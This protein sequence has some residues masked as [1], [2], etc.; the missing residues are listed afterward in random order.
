MVPAS[1]MRSQSSHLTHPQTLWRPAGTCRGT[2]RIKGL[3]K[4]RNKAFPANSRCQNTPATRKP[5]LCQ[6]QR[7]SKYRVSEA[8]LSCSI[9]DQGH[10]N[11]TFTNKALYELMALSPLQALGESDKNPQLTSRTA[12][13]QLPGQGE[14]TKMLIFIPVSLNTPSFCTPCLHSIR[15]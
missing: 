6:N 5:F 10:T 9:S 4:Q 11:K 2:A 14:K 1:W 3:N 12:R 13:K 7:S 8:A 15:A